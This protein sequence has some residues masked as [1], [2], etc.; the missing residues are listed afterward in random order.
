MMEY[1]EDNGILAKEQFGSRKN[2]SAIEH[3]INKRL[4]LDFSRQQKITCVYI[5]ND[6]KSCYDRILLM[7]A[8]LAMRKAGVA[9]KAAYSSIKTLVGMTM[10]IKT[11]HGTSEL[12]YG[13]NEWET[14]PHGIGQ[15]NGYG[16][17]IWAII[18]SPLLQIMRNKG[19]GTSIHS[20]IT[21]ETLQMAGFSFVDDTDQCEMTMASKSWEEQLRD[22]QS[23]IELWESLLRTTGGAVEPSKSDWT[24]LKYK[25]DDSGRA[26]LM[27]PQ[28]T[29]KLYMKNPDGQVQELTQ[30]K[31]SDARETL[32]VWQTATG[33]EDTQIRKLQSKIASWG[34]KIQQ[35]GINKS[36]T[37]TAVKITIGKTIR[38]PLGATTINMKEAQ[39]IDKEFRWATLGKMNVVRT[40]LAYA[41][42]APTKYGGLGMGNEVY[43]NQMIDHSL[44][45]LSHGHTKST[46][47]TLLRTSLESLSIES[48]IGGDPGTFDVQNMTWITENT[49]V[50]GTLQSYSEYN[51]ELETSISGLRMWTTRD[52][53]IMEKAF[54][55]LSSPRSIRIFNKVR[56]YLKVATLSDILIADGTEVDHNIFQGIRSNS[57]TLSEHAYTW[58][59]VPEPSG[60][61]IHIWYAT[62]EKMLRIT[63][64]RP[65]LLTET[66]FRWD[67]KYV[68]LS[69]WTTDQ[70]ETYLY[71]K[72][73]NKWR[74]W[75]RQDGDKG[76]R[77]TRRR[78]IRYMH[79]DTID[80]VNHIVLPITV[81]EEENG[82]R[83]ILSKGQVTTFEEDS[84]QL[85]GIGWI[86]PCIQSETS[87]EHIFVDQ[88]V[89]GEGIMVS[90]G[91]FKNNRSSAAFTTVPG[92]AIRGVLTIP[93]NESEQSS[94]R[95]ELGGILASIVY[96]NQIC[97]KYNIT[98]GQCTMI[99]DNK[100]A[101]ASSFGNRQLNPRWTCYDIL[102]MIRF[103]LES[104]PLTWRHKHVKGHQDNDIKYEELDIVSQANVD[105]DNLAKIEL[106][107]N[108]AIDDTQVLLGQCWRLRHK[109]TREVIQGS[110]ESVLR[111]IIYENKMKKTWKT[112]FSIQR[113]ITKEEWNLMKK[114]NKSHNEEEHLF[115]VK[116]ALGILATKKNMVRRK[117]DDNDKCP[118]CDL[119]EDTE[120]ILKCKSTTQQDTY[121]IERE[122]LDIFLQQVTTWELREAILEL[123]Q[124]FRD[125][126]EP[127][128]AR[129]WSIRTSEMTREQYDLGQRAFFSGLWIDKWVKAQ[130]EFQT[131]KKRRTQ[132][133]TVIVKITRRVQK[134][135]REMWHNRND[136]LHR[137]EESRINRD[138]HQK[139]DQQ[140]DTLY[141]RKAAIHSRLLAIADAR[142]FRRDKRTLKKRR[143]AQKERW[144]RDAEDILNKYVE[145][146]NTEQVR[147]FLAFFTSSGDRS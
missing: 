27:Q 139:L 76:R 78:S 80:V 15:G 126:K 37:L 130:D 91:S 102:C 81:T 117:H 111:R 105:V 38:Y 11:M 28:V 71:E 43:V 22:T 51:L 60:S 12:N 119:V 59:V 13:G 146:H 75:K 20:P 74:R 143:L 122:S 39:K 66:A 95:S 23:S 135:I 115:S 90:D 54:E 42:A 7:V 4:T 46:T 94:Y 147:N 96:A 52:E 106:E 6:A 145:D 127:T 101:L 40:A 116:H 138:R 79:T 84:D 103:H 123:I 61:E 124:S 83:S 26:T 8:Y 100:G 125:S 133:M 64:N 137:N 77:R 5:A 109:V 19:Y 92:K 10:C 16:P 82:M 50:G 24:K 88:L 104:S 128:I 68:K 32:G 57:P 53:F 14:Y 18:S 34:K 97:A 48:G 9:R 120:H 132:G 98:E 62:I 41:T 140:I 86:L 1:A 99:C 121:S 118:C 30:H 67:T 112:K 110:T 17:A 73:Q 63:R 49:W 87:D 47:G 107:R 55:H 65:R 93:G 89:K 69:K 45:I 136:E 58:P 114:F 141:S 2:K 31:A 35:S 131:E 72:I 108:R 56:L 144:V 70:D 142:Y 33:S 25:W 134:I 113:D 36:E 3:A 29:D 85:E 129:R 21:K 44:V